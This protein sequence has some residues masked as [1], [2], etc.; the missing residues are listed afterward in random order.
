MKY[1]LF[2]AVGSA[3]LFLS[4]FAMLATFKIWLYFASLI[5]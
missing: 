1:L 2:F 4:Y 3:V 5:A